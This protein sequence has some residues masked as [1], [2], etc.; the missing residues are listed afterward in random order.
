MNGPSTHLSWSELACKDG[1]PY[2]SEWR[3]S[4][5]IQLA[6]VFEL[7]RSK[8]GD[9]PIQILSA[10]RTPS[11][12]KKIGGAKNSQHKEGRAM[13]LKPPEGW[14][15]MAFYE[16]I[17]ELSKISAIRGIGR[18]ATFVHVDIRPG[19]YL[20]LWTGSGTKDS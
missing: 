18:Y 10:Y 7:I 3:D 16:L 1:T 20:A 15:V 11:W 17:K 2:P 6:G 4:R 8:C 12:N 19:G 13:D 9:K 5:A 14:S